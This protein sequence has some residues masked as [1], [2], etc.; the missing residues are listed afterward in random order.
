[1][2][3]RKPKFWET[4]AQRQTRRKE[5]VSKTTK[6][7]VCAV[8]SAAPQT[9]DTVD[10]TSLPWRGVSVRNDGDAAKKSPVICEPLAASAIPAELR[11]HVCVRASE[12][13]AG[14]ASHGS[15]TQRAHARQIHTDWINADDWTNREET[16]PGSQTKTWKEPRTR[17]DAAPAGVAPSGSNTSAHAPIIGIQILR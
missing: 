5:Q 7:T 10:K 2:S 9:D 17:W 13:E 12:R 4:T 16:L 15:S 3:R 6:S 14:R 1:M 11:A 8:S